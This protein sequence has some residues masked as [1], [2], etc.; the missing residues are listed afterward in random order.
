MTVWCAVD[1]P[2]TSINF[3]NSAVP[4]NM[5]WPITLDWDKTMCHPPV[6]NKTPHS[7]KLPPQGTKSLSAV[8]PH[9]A[10]KEG[11][12]HLPHELHLGTLVVDGDVLAQELSGRD[13]QD[14]G[15][16]QCLLLQPQA[17]AHALWGCTAF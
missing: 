1:T 3:E 2:N 17:L 9:R 14:A 7:A 16:A 15:V 10:T 5:D 6:P 8:T 4:P 12:A 13:I 11:L